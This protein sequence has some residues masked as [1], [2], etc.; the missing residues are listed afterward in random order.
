MS[1]ASNKKSKVQFVKD[2]DTNKQ[3]N[4]LKSSNV[5]NKSTLIFKLDK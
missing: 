4:Y 3:T 2:Y 1:I 5:I